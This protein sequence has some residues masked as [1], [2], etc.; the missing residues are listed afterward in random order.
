MNKVLITIYVASIDEEFDIFIPIGIKMSDVLDVIQDSIIE[1]SNGNYVKKEE[2]SLYNSDGLLINI[3][4]IV[5]FS[6]VKN[7][8]KLMLI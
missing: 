7:G 5:K 4:N 6:G 2:V 3:N 1:L 8:L